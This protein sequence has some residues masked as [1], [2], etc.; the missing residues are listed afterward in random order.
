MIDH[1]TLIV[2]DYDKS[3]PFY[4]AALEPL[5]YQAVMTLTREQMPD[6]PFAEA[7]GLGADGKPDLWLRPPVGDERVTPTHIAF[8]AKSHADVD[9]FHISLCLLANPPFPCP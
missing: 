5:G 9:A 2:S 1:I 8:A 4:L 3:K 7:V 6:L